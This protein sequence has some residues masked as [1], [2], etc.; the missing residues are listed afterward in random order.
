MEGRNRER[1]FKQFITS[2]HFSVCEE[3]K[4]SLACNRRPWEFHEKIEFKIKVSRNKSNFSLPEGLAF[5]DSTGTRLSSMR[6]KQ[7]PS[8]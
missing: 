7:F 2:W 6:E 8:K 1:V 5:F 4:L 3:N